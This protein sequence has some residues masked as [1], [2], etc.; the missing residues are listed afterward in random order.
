MTPQERIK[1]I[2]NL[3]TQI[4]N[5]GI[6]QDIEYKEPYIIVYFSEYLDGLQGIRM[7]FNHNKG[8]A[9]KTILDRILELQAKDSM[10]KEVL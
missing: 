2:E 5:T 8:L 6:V 1:N 10:F 3:E 9:L 7:A 4:F